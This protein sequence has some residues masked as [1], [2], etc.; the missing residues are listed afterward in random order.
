MREM[1][2][3]AYKFATRRWIAE[4]DTTERDWTEKVSPGD[5]MYCI[6]ITVNTILD[7][8]QLLRD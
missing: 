3:K 1:L 2:D 4:S 6:V 7:K 5:L 8:S